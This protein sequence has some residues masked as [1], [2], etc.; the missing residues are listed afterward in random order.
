MTRAGAA[1]QQARF[2]SLIFCG[3][4]DAKLIAKLPRAAADISVVDLEDATPVSL[5]ESAR[6]TANAEGLRL[7]ES[8]WDQPL[9]LRVN[10]FDTPWASRDILEADF[11]VFDGIV[12]PKAEGPATAVVIEALLS[13]LGRTLASVRWIAGLETA[14]GIERIDAILGG[15]WRPAALYFG[16]HDYARSVG[17]RH[18]RGSL[19][20][21]YA[22]SRVAAWAG[23]TGV[24][25]FD[26]AV[27]EIRDQD[28]FTAE[29]EAGRN[30][31]FAGKLCLNPAQVSWANAAFS[32]TPEEIAYAQSVL[33]EFQRVKSEGRGV[34]IIDGVFI[35]EVTVRQ[36]RAVLSASGFSAHG[37][38]D[39]TDDPPKR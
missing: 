9:Y 22:R 35:D 11:D 24:P 2:R 7:R 17:G 1:D 18:T 38:G 21:L 30:L 33:D 8:G 4:W 26:Q 23:I 5:K 19:E 32:P 15:E 29:A 20:V 37:P 39:A 14:L 16:G 27:A 10:A 31:G 13:A 28:L 36:A 12:V 25:A 3:A 34:A 6:A